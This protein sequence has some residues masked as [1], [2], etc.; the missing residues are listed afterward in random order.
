MGFKGDLTLDCCV[1]VCVCASLQVLPLEWICLSWE[2]RRGGRTV[3]G[4]SLETVEAAGNDQQVIWQLGMRSSI[5]EVAGSGDDQ[6]C[7]LVRPKS[8]AG[9][10]FLLLLLLAAVAV[11]GAA[12]ERPARCQLCSQALLLAAQWNASPP[13]ST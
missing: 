4:A 8:S 12:G 5:P 3:A 7:D 2:G 6:R 9:W 10:H 1:S 11:V 13:G